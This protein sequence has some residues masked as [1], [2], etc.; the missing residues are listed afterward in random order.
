MFFHHPKLTQTRHILI[1]ELRSL[2]C[3]ETSHKGVAAEKLQFCI[4]GTK[5]IHSHW[6]TLCACVRAWKELLTALKPFG[7][8]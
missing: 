5:Y 7:F 6:F 4:S 3:F 8:K 2:K 1:L